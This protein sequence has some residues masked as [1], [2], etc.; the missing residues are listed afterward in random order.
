MGLSGQ[1]RIWAFTLSDME[2]TWEFSSGEWCGWTLGW[3]LLGCQAHNELQNTR[4][5]TDKEA[6]W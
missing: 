3:K 4:V 2:V 1:R 6:L 5:E